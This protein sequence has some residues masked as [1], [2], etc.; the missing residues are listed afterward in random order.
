[1]I[2]VKVKQLMHHYFHQKKKQLLLNIDESI[3]DY[4]KDCAL[5]VTKLR[6]CKNEFIENDYADQQIEDSYKDRLEEYSNLAER[7]KSDIHHP[8]DKWLKKDQNQDHKQKI[9]IL[10]NIKETCY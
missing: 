5:L 9:I 10:E 2:N 3:E 6:H 4:R 1:M 8:I 7:Y